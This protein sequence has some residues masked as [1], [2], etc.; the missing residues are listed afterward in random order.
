LKKD[1]KIS[2]IFLQKEKKVPLSRNLLN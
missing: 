1:C 2:A